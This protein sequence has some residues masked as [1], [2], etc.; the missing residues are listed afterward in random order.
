MTGPARGGADPGVAAAF[1]E[2]MA[3][4][5]APVAVMTGLEGG[6]PHGTTVSAFASLSMNPP[7]VL[8]ALDR[9]SELLALVRR[10]RR[11]GLNLL[12][13]GQAGLARRFA[14]KGGA[15]KFAGVAWEPHAGVPRIPGSAGF[16]GCTVAGL[17]H[18]GDHL[19]VLGNV[20]AAETTGDAPLVYH[21]RT[22]GTPAA[23]P[24]VSG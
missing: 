3:A 6:L 1:R 10:T 20:V 16:V 7:M 2:T 21:R 12:G 13:A 24:E 9:T 8:V 5:C 18:G 17:A 19:I 14:A 11:F 15:A 22:F 4:V 23:L